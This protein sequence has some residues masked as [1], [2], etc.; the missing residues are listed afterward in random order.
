MNSFSGKIRSQSQLVAESLREAILQGRCAPGERL[1]SIR[2]L[3]EEFGVGRQVILSAF[4]MLAREKMLIMHPSSGTFV[5]PEFQIPKNCCRI[6][7]YSHRG[8]IA[9][10]YSGA[11][12]E[13][14]CH[15]A[16]E[17]KH[18]LTLHP[19]RPELPLQKQFIHDD[20]LI[21][22]GEV[23]DDL[24]SELDQLG[25]P[26]VVIGNVDIL[27]PANRILWDID[28]DMDM[29]FRIVMESFDI[30]SAG[31]TIS[32]KSFFANKQMIRAFQR[33][34][35][36]YNISF[37]SEDSISQNLPDGYSAMTAMCKN[38]TVPFPDFV[39]IS[40]N[41]YPGAETF[42]T[43]HPE[44]KRPVI[45]STVRDGNIP[46]CACKNTILASNIGNTAKEGID[47]LLGLLSG[48]LQNYQVRIA[49]LKNRKFF[50]YNELGEAAFK[51][52]VDGDPGKNGF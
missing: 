20:G 3:A 23:D 46:L 11:L 16:N 49:S 41:Q 5:N 7:F 35:K 51:V 4:N 25:K 31:M 13:Q 44:I 28:G 33:N 14:S 27:K 36:K 38:G 39:F 8:T 37:L 42:F 43:E 22:S 10:N 17:L 29:I 1:K 48:N 12:F 6:G 15:Y 52:C 50:I 21:V 34:I 26:F 40:T 24:I 32:S 30:H 9:S 18:E 47:L 2:K 45:F 19:Y